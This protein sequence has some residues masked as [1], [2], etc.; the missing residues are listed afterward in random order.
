MLEFMQMKCESCGYFVDTDK[1][2]FEAHSNKC[3]DCFLKEKEK[4]D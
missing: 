3:E 1:A 2:S 4:N